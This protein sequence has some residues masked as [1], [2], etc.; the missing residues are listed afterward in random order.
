MG[1]INVQLHER[2]LTMHHVRR[3]GEKESFKRTMHKTSR[4]FIIL[5]QTGCTM[6][7]FAPMYSHDINLG[8]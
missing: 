5:F 4:T 2:G 6:I 8:M 1:S 7:G 3:G